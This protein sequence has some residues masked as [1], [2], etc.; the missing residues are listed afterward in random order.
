M[1][2][3]ASIALAT[4][5]VAAG[6]AH[7]AAQQDSQATRLLA[8]AHHKATVVGDLRGA[9]EDYKRIVDG[10]GSNRALAAEALLRMAECHQK[11]GEAEAQAIYARIVR[12]YGDQTAV[13]STARTRVA[14]QAIAQPGI[15][16][17]RRVCAGCVGDKIKDFTL[18][19]DGRWIGYTAGEGTQASNDDDLMVRDLTN[20]E[21]RR[22]VDVPAVG[23][24][25]PTHFAARRATWS[26][27][28]RQVAYQFRDATAKRPE[29]RVM[30]NR[31]GGRTVTLV[32]NPE[33]E[34]VLPT[35][36]SPDGKSILVMIERRDLTWQLAWVSANTG[37]ITVLKSLNWQFDE[38]GNGPELSPDGR[39][40]VYNAFT[41]LRS[42]A[43][44]QAGD[45][46]TLYILA[47][48]GSSETA[49]VGA[50]SEDSFPVWA[51]DGSRVFF[52][53]DTLT[54]SPDL[55]SIAVRDGRA[56]GAPSVVKAGIGWAPLVGVTRAG[57]L[58]H[59]M[60]KE[61][62]PR[63]LL[64]DIGS[65]RSAG[66]PTA[67]AGRFG[68]PAWSPDGRRI[69]S[70][71][72]PSDGRVVIHSLDTSADQT[73]TLG[74]VTRPSRPR[75]YH[76]GSALL[77]RGRDGSRTVLVRIDLRTSAVSRLVEF[78]A[79]AHPADLRSV[80]P[81]QTDF[82]LS[83]EGTT[84]YFGAGKA[85]DQKDR[86]LAVDLATGQARQIAV[87][88]NAN[89]SSVATRPDG[90]T[91]ATTFASGPVSRNAGGV[92]DAPTSSH[93][94]VVGI[95][96]TPWQTLYG[97]VVGRSEPGT[98]NTFPR[99]SEP[100]WSEDGRSILFGRH[101][102]DGSW[103]LWRVPAAGGEP[104][105]IGAMTSDEVKRNGANPG[106][107]TLTADGKRAAHFG[108]ATIRAS[109]ELWALDL[110]ALLKSAA[111]DR[112]TR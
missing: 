42:S 28:M 22:L 18:S 43:R 103:T 8:G 6:L 53:S 54:R 66:V 88:P 67:L 4:V 72:A 64:E 24:A 107:L 77:V 7:V 104:D 3:L 94:A 111:V 80:F 49:V 34:Y 48:D 41:K 78:D 95:D 23:D 14:S 83:P 63:T 85:F 2:R 110:S 12:D 65:G 27:D 30:E 9:I 32:D 35:A 25:Q 5:L 76:D 47:A 70:V 69:A 46:Y 52:V 38:F 108:R 86:I 15:G 26:P 96:G 29:L 20:G 105:R 112:R 93:V 55:L 19:P 74:G 100:T 87:L 81:A 79:S 60:P 39:H 37:A 45:D 98:M 73:Y 13:A 40:I 50:A 56:T 33:F 62:Y 51:P 82:A 109:N 21:T 57:V 84:V 91:L 92:P 61:S 89:I 36:W 101:E 99:L 59:V 71:S 75:W 17:G 68:T 106:G 102:D 44:D 16:E 97:P 58:Y 31:P 90:R 10:A 1:T 11:L